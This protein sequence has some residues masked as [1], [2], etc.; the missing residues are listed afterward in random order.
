MTEDE[1]GRTKSEKSDSDRSL[2]SQEQL[3]YELKN[4]IGEL[5]QKIEEKEQFQ[6]KK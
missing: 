3:V 5:E 6:S 2:S 4:N 1:L